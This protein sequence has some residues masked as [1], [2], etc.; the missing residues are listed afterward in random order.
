L[1]YTTA[2]MVGLILITAL[3]FEH[4]TENEISLKALK[5]SK[6]AIKILSALTNLLNFERLKICQIPTQPYIIDIGGDMIE[7]YRI[8]TGKYHRSVRAYCGQSFKYCMY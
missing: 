2:C 4:Y 5:R 1:A 7:K 6:K 8:V 3:L